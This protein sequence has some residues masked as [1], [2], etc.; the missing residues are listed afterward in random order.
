MRDKLKSAI[1][2][3]GI[4]ALLSVIP[5]LGYGFFFWAIAGG[6]LASYLYIKKS[7]TPVQI[8]EGLLLG[9]MSGIV[10]SLL[11]LC[12]VIPITYFTLSDK[13]IN[14]DSIVIAGYNVSLDPAYPANEWERDAPGVFL[15]AF[16]I[17][18]VIFIFT[19]VGGVIGVPLFEKRKA[20]SIVQPSSTDAGV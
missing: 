20:N 16:L 14:K 18:V 15:I 12:I 1:I 9:A 13:P 11:Y 7:P 6:V 19:T 10:G 5:L 4:I 2:A 3:G 8:A 17:I